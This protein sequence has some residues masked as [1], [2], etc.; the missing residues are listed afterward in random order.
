[1]IFLEDQDEKKEEIQ[2]AINEF[3]DLNKIDLEILKKNKKYLEDMIIILKNNYNISLRKI[4]D[5]LN[6]GGYVSKIVEASAVIDMLLPFLKVS[7]KAA[8]AFEKRFEYAA[9]HCFAEQTGD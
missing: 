4:A 6:I 3:L 2:N 1:M 7:K 9:R 8:A 5:Y